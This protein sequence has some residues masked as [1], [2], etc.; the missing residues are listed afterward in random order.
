[1][2]VALLLGLTM[3]SFAYLLLNHFAGKHISAN[4]RYIA[5]L[6]L[7]AAFLLPFKISLVQIPMPDFMGTESKDMETVTVDFHKGD[8]TAVISESGEP[9]TQDRED[10]TLSLAKRICIIVYLSGV[11][12]A[13][14]WTAH[15]HLVLRKTL[16]RSLV[17]PSS[18]LLWQFDML[19]GKMDIQRRPK[20]LVCRAPVAL[21]LGA[22]FTF[23][24]IH[25]KV[26]MPSNVCGEDA[27]ML[28]G[29]ELCHCK[30]HDSLFRLALVAVSVMYWFYLPIVPFVHTLFAVC[31]ESCDAK[32]TEY[33]SGEDRAAYGKLLIRYA[34]KSTVLP[35][36][37]S[38]TGKKLKKRIETLFSEKHR[39]EGYAL[40]CVMVYALVFLMGTSFSAPINKTV[41]KTGSDCF[42]YMQEDS[43]KSGIHMMKGE[44]YH[45][46]SQKGRLN[47]LSL[48]RY[49]TQTGELAYVNTDNFCYL[50]RFISTVIV[51]SSDK[52]DFSAV[53]TYCDE[54]TARSCVGLRLIYNGERK[55]DG[56]MD[57]AHI[58]VLSDWAL[59]DYYVWLLLPEAER[60]ATFYDIPAY[61]AEDGWE[62]HILELVNE[63]DASLV[64]FYRALIEKVS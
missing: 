48:C 49:A 19:C 46:F 8:S 1:M 14:L 63:K 5:G 22:P 2:S 7:L 61:Y 15:R 23:G 44:L 50:D 18:E 38:S 34:S 45:A 16:M 3:L 40:I 59:L 64:P 17:E 25:Q 4:T 53:S 6:I 62:E 39:C 57:Y 29:H 27:E 10:E 12:I 42:S 60:G 24:V 56:D 11:L 52:K 35:V 31:E 26:V 33:K 13:S 37:F 9:L 47:Q 58:V 55:E 51:E 21:S 41:I 30:Q 28:L 36:S 43:P 32:M 54:N 20:L